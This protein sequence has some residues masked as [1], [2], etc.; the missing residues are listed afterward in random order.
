MDPTDGNT[1]PGFITIPT[2]RGRNSSATGLRVPATRGRINALAE[3]S[4]PTTKWKP[5]N[6]PTGHVTV[7]TTRAGYYQT[8][9]GFSSEGSSDGVNNSRKTLA[10]T[11]TCEKIRQLVYKIWEQ[12]K[13]EASAAIAKAGAWQADINDLRSAFLPP[14]ELKKRHYPKD[15]EKFLEVYNRMF[16]T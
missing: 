15:Y 7:P 16:C 11:T 12:R 4:V 9:P 10:A 1:Q 14:E 3:F 8:S 2:T 5:Y 13:A 6:A